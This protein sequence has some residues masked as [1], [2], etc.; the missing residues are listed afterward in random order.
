LAL[1]VLVVVPACCAVRFMLLLSALGRSS[2]L[3]EIEAHTAST[4]QL[5]ASPNERIV[6]SAQKRRRS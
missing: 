6:Y 3:A 1:F 5:H 2:I 4:Q